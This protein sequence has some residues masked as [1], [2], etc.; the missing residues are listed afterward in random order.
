MSL[1]F[2]AVSSLTVLS[3]FGLPARAGDRARNLETAEA[4]DPLL[5]MLGLAGQAE[6]PKP[7][8]AGKRAADRT[9]S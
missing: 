7:P 2:A 9:R 3:P 8:E 1:K 4:H 5:A 6:Q